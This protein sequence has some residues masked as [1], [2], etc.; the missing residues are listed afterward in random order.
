MTLLLKAGFLLCAAALAAQ[1][2]TASLYDR[3]RAAFD[4]HRY[5]E[6]AAL[7]SRAE[8]ADPGHS[9]SLLFEGKALA[10][11]GR[12]P[13]SDQA[14]RRY[15]ARNPNAAD[16]HYMLGFVLHRE[17]QPKDSLAEYTQA[18]R[19]TPPQSDD[20]KI[21]ALD[22]VLLNDY[23]DAIHWFE[24]SVAFDAA[25]REAWYGL[26]RCYYTQSRFT[27]AERAFQRSLALKPGDIK[28]LTNLGL[29]YEMQNRLDDA[30]RTYAQAVALARNDP[31]SDEW[32]YLNYASFLLD[33]SRAADAIPLLEQA[34]R[35]SPRCA[36]CHL[37]QGRALAAAGKQAEAIAELRQAVALSPGDPKMHYELGRA[38][39]A[40]GQMEQAKAELALS[41][42]LYGA[43]ATDG[44]K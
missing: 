18:A 44:A 14:L 6:A 36:D 37:K 3:A 28:T 19:F 11:I 43:K 10:N 25:N 15:L 29:V 24:Q 5:A 12:F 1:S 13:E 21:V 27:E 8:A 42:K 38:Y 16:A 22:Y 26:G 34:I 40:A 31:Q 35:I 30:D 2:Q 39:R 32:P 9:D 17:N 23:P 41:A 33:N 4:A 7:F 20:L